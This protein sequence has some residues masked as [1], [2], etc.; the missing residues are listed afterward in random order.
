MKIAF[1][2][3]KELFFF[4]N[5]TPIKKLMKTL[6]DLLTFHVIKQLQNTQAK[7]DVIGTSNDCSRKVVCQLAKEGK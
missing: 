3:F 7:L 6:K 1:N 4:F 5:L 2:Q